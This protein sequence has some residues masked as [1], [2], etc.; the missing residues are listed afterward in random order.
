MTIIMKLRRMAIA[1]NA[2]RPVRRTRMRALQAI[3]FAKDDVT[4]ARA[5]NKLYAC[6]TWERF[7]A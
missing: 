7:H 5:I 2:R 1:N 4:R 3:R 6:T